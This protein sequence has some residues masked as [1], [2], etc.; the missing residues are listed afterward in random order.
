MLIYCYMT[1]VMFGDMLD[2]DSTMFMTIKYVIIVIEFL[3]DTSKLKSI[4]IERRIYSQA[5]QNK[6]LTCSINKLTTVTCES[7]NTFICE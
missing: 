4:F 6:A 1:D 5:L 2:A 7:A 3:V